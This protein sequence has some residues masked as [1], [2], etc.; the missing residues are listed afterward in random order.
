MSRYVVT[1]APRAV[2]T[3]GRAS[4]AAG[5]TATVVRDADTGEFNIEAG[6]LLLADNVLSSSLFNF[7]VFEF[8]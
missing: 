8:I 6:A 3:S 1:L 7:E 2:Y 5:L 4:S